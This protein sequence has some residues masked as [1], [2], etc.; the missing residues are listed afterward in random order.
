MSPPVVVRI[1]ARAALV[2]GL[3]LRRGPP[4]VPR[5]VVPV[6]VW[7]AVE[8]VIVGRAQPHVVEEGAEA[9]PP[10]WADR[11]STAAIAHPR[12]HVPIRAALLHV[13]P[14]PVL[15]HLGERKDALATRRAVA[16]PLAL[17]FPETVHRTAKLAI[18]A[19][20]GFQPGLGGTSV[21][22]RGVAAARAVVG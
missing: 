21:H 4:N 16:S 14:D 19:A 2:V 10:L 15:W 5:L 3:L 12:W 8:A 7:V 13:H 9:R 22:G 11:D 6:V 20:P 17:S 18:A 1:A